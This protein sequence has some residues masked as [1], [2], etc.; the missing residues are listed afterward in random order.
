MKAFLCAVAF[1]SVVACTQ[2][3]TPVADTRDADL[4]AIAAIQ[5]G[6]EKAWVAKDMEAI[7]SQY[8]PE[9]TLV[10][11]NAPVAKGTTA[12]RGMLAEL[13]KDPALQLSMETTS[14]DVSG[15]IG[16]LRGNYTIQMTDP[17]TKKP[18]T[19]RGSVLSVFR[20]QA[21][22]NWRITEDFNS[23]GPADAPAA[24]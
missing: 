22:G 13:L 1:V 12:I 10:V 15:N 3:P 11:T 20:K 7:M 2:A 8:A 24:K 4:K 17:K 23:A 16:I 14:T 5:A 6:A 21:D 19:E 18:M 9:A